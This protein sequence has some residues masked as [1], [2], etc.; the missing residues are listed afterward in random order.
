[1]DTDA[2][3]SA[4]SVC[5][6]PDVKDATSIATIHGRDVAPSD[7]L[8]LWKDLPVTSVTSTLVNTLHSVVR[9]P[10]RPRIL[11]RHAIMSI[12]TYRAVFL[13]PREK[14]ERFGLAAAVSRY[15]LSVSVNCGSAA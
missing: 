1:M 9:Q 4:A 8:T 13:R 15:S 6:H 3:K 10:E 14:M 7:A 5:E 12:V 2:A 11:L